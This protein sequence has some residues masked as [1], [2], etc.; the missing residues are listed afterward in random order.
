MQKHF[1]ILLLA[2]VS[3]CII[4]TVQA[5]KRQ[6]KNSKATQK[7]VAK[8][9]SSKKTTNK[10][11]VTK[12]NTTKKTVAKNANTE[13][14]T[15]T[16]ETTTTKTSVNLQDT[17]KPGVVVLYA[18]FKPSLRNAAKINFNAATPFTDTTKSVV[19]YKVPAQNLFFSYQPVPIK[20]VALI[21]DSGYKW[22]NH[23]YIKLGFGSFSTPFAQVGLSFGDG[24]NKTTSVNAFH[25][26]SKGKLPFQQFSKTAL[27]LLGNYAAQNNHEWQTKFYYNN[28]NHYLYGYQPSSLNFTKDSLNR[29]YND[30][31][32]TVGYNRKLPNDY[33]FT[34]NPSL[35]LG[36]YFDNKKATEFNALLKVPVSKILNELVTLNFNLLADITSYKNNTSTVSN[37][38]FALNAIATYK[39]NNFLINAGINP[40]W[41][42]NEV[43]LLPDL[44]AEIKLKEIKASV[45]GG[46]KGYFIKNNYRSLSTYNPFIKQPTDLFNSKV[47]EIF[48]GI[49]GAA[50]THLTYNG[51][52]SFLT[53]KDVPIFIN[54]GADGKTFLV[55]NDS[56]LDAVK[57]HGEVGYN[58]QEKFAFL[59]GINMYQ[60]TKST[61]D[62]PFG[63]VPM[64]VTGTLKWKMLKDLYVKANLFFW[65]GIK[66]LNKTNLQTY[67]LNAAMDLNAGVEYTIMPKLNLWLQFNNLLNSKY[68]RWNQYESLG[69]NVVGGIVYSF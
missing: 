38:L 66:Y 18:V 65:D 9:T 29:M 61:Y 52:L 69:L 11:T 13:T 4:T 53:M 59:A 34:Y 47:N 44:S 27:S 5:Q 45:E 40:S 67:K 57:I 10:K 62:K 63:L 39:T 37:N 3:C 30:I 16:T 26:S 68:Q 51:R 22:V 36:Y 17:T 2:I 28:N 24:K 48:A 64:E 35:N 58:I 19:N 23:H 7:T 54:D 31:G 8:K 1:K 60:F 21:P 46:W 56:A 50:G 33:G 15:A 55:I 32:A 20:P 41:N 49:K 25:T 14:T 6:K 43:A 12:K 42:K